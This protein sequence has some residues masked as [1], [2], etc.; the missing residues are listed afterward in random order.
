VRERPSWDEYFLGIAEAVSRRSHDAET[1]VGCVIVG[2]DRRILSTGYNGFAPGLPDYK[3]PNTRPAK[4]PYMIHAEANAIATAKTDLRGATCYCLFS[5]CN[6]CAKLLLAAGIDRVVCSQAYWNSD[7][8][9]IQELLKMGGVEVV[10]LKEV[11]H[12]G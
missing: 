12:S 7:W 1:Q 3:L 6:D 2:T 4:Y 10:V 5:P 11:E 9:K 8:D